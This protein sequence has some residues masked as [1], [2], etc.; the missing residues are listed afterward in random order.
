MRTLTITDEKAHFLVTKSR[1]QMLVGSQFFGHLSLKMRLREDEDIG[2]MATDGTRLYYAP[3]FVH[4]IVTG[5]A[6]PI[7]GFEKLLGVIAHETMHNALKHP[8]RMG[9]R[10]P[11]LWNIACDYV[12]NNI[13]LEAK[14]EGRQSSFILPEGALVDARFKGLAAEHVYAV[15]AKEISQGKIPQG[16]KVLIVLSK[17]KGKG[18]KDDQDGNGKGDPYGLDGVMDVLPTGKMIHPREREDQMEDDG[19]GGDGDMDPEGADMTE[20]DWE[21]AVTIAEKITEKHYGNMPL[22]IT[23]AVKASKVRRKNV[24]EVLKRFVEHTVARD[25]SWSHP[26]RQYLAP[27]DEHPDGLIL[28]G[29][30]KENLPR[31]VVG[32]DTSGSMFWGHGLEILQQLNAR[33]SQI[34]LEYRPE[35]L[36]VYYCD[37]K[38]QKFESFEPDDG[39]VEIEDGKDLTS[40][41]VGGGGTAFEPVFKAVEKDRIKRGKP[42]FM[43]YFTDL[44]GPFPEAPDYPVLW[45]TS[46]STNEKAPWGETIHLPHPDEV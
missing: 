34:L 8:Y 29:Y 6:N 20:T 4:G 39:R 25:H 33:L 19:S 44:E 18:E 32:I 40:S 15:L 31:G 2:T 43:L 35:S 16:I 5:D 11:A 42:A 7:N 46:G 21:G 38:V 27:S 12:I 1:S 24:W 28:P 41:F 17:A 3:S 30:Y 26:R 37:T 23:Q 22:G 36:D 45:V 10:N 13:L 14:R 9:N